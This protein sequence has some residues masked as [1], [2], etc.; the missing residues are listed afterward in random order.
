MG[1][2]AAA[3]ITFFLIPYTRLI[4]GTDPLSSKVAEFLLAT[5]AVS[6]G[7]ALMAGLLSASPARQAGLLPRSPWLIIGVA[8][9]AAISA[10][11]L[12]FMSLALKDRPA[13]GLPL[14][15]LGA[16]IPALPIAAGFLALASRSAALPLFR[17]AAVVAFAALVAAPA[18]AFALDRDSR[19][20]DAAHRA[21]FEQKLEALRNLPAG[22]PVA[23]LL[24]HYSF[25]AR[26]GALR[27]EVERRIPEATGSLANELDG[28]NGLVAAVL[29]S[30]GTADADTRRRALRVLYQT[31][32]RFAE[33]MRTSDKP[34][35]DEFNEVIIAT[36]AIANQSDD[37]LPEMQGE[38]RAIRGAQGLAYE[39]AR[40]VLRGGLEA[41]ERP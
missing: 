6:Q 10:W 26:D 5:L 24:P 8:V 34:S 4:H 35:R 27:D 41:F 39:Q 12:N 18:A 37:I 9:S 16:V 25:E 28:P 17:T 20:A 21:R 11:I 22:S 29:V 15:L 7:A 40:Y 36:I 19:N 2:A 1:L 14:A 13:A 30:R 38:I 23:E 3:A 33:R 32:L 31:A